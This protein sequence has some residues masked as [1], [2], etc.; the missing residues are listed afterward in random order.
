M[1]TDPATGYLVAGEHY[2]LSGFDAQ[3][4]RQF[5][6]LYKETGNFSACAKAVG[7]ARR[8]VYSHL[9]N[10]PL[11]KEQF[12]DAVHT[13]KDEF[14]GV[15]VSNGKRPNGFMDRMAWLRARFSEYNPKTTISHES[16]PDVGSLMAA[17]K[18]CGQVIDVKPESQP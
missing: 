9:E 4:K 3:S 12:D 5:I 17:L 2:A 11:F 18:D 7:V 15:M 10:D 8:T 14:E 6:D 16:K 13:I 1:R